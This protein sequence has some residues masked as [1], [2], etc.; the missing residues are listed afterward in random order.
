MREALSVE[1]PRT[2][3]HWEFTLRVLIT[4]PSASKNS[5]LNPASSLLPLQVCGGRGE[6]ETQVP[7]QIWMPPLSRLDA[8]ANPSLTPQQKP[9][10]LHFALRSD[11]LPGRQPL[12]V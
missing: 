10:Y 2:L 12:L 9:H 6:A 7:S 4:Q 5:P 1:G 8:L 11:T 3:L